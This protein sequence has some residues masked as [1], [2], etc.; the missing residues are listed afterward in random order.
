MR[1]FTLIAVV[2]ALVVASCGGEA[3]TSDPEPDD[4]LAEAITGK[5]LENPDRNF[6]D[7]AAACLARSIVDEFGVD[8]LAGLGVTADNPDLMGGSV[9]GTPDNGRRVVDLGMECIDVS[10]AIVSFLPHGVTLLEESVECVAD[11]LQT[12]TFRDLLAAIVIAG[13]EPSDILDNAAA[14]VPMGILLFSCL[15]A[16]EIL[17]IGD[18]LD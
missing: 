2:A 1:R 5:A 11:G 12:D 9:F 18:L 4:E 17:R 13:A 7:E 6:D 8:G 10:E 3:S 16:G 15:D 14:Q